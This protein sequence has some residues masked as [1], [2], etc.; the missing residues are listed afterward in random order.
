VVKQPIIIRAYGGTDFQKCLAGRRGEGASR[1]RLV[2]KTEEE[3]KEDGKILS[4]MPDNYRKCLE[5]LMHTRDR[6]ER[7]EL[8]KK[9]K[10]ITP[11]F[12]SADQPKKWQQALRKDKSLLIWNE[13]SGLQQAL[14][15]SKTRIP[16]FY[17]PLDLDEQKL[18]FQPQK[19]AEYD[20]IS[21]RQ[22]ELTRLV[23]D[24][25]KDAIKEVT[26]GAFETIEQHLKAYAR[27]TSGMHPGVQWRLPQD[28]K[29]GFEVNHYRIE[30]YQSGE[31]RKDSPFHPRS[32]YRARLPD[33]YKKGKLSHKS[34]TDRLTKLHKASVFNSSK[35]PEIK[36]DLRQLK[37]IRGER[38][39]KETA[40]NFL[41][42][43][44]P[45]RNN[46]EVEEIR[47]ILSHF[48]ISLLRY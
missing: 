10:K 22:N 11:V 39:Y 3:N 41:N 34:I 46:E 1:R 12:T 36:K 26:E 35:S 25:I 42:K 5:R 17:V 20:I 6:D 28:I 24:A 13:G 19:R 43:Y 4:D 33:W 44:H 29:N 48:E 40:D 16:A 15:D 8:N 30:A 2:L 32:V 14:T 18:K 21:R 47:R 7:K 31:T 9:L 45:G 27:E 23:T 37:K 38:I